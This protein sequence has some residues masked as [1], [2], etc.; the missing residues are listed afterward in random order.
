MTALDVSYSKFEQFEATEYPK[1]SQ[2]DLSE[3]DTRSKLIDHLMMDVLGW[4]EPDIEREGHARD[5]FFDYEMSTAVFRFVIEAKRVQVTL[6]LPVSGNRVKLRTIYK[7]NKEAIDQ[8][9][10]YLFERSLQYGVLT[11]GHQFIIA[12]FVGQT[13]DDWRDGDAMFFKSFD[14]IKK[15]FNLFYELLSRE[16]VM[17][18]ARIKIAHD[19]TQA[20]LI[21]KMDLAHKHA[22]LNRNHASPQLIPILNTVFE[23]LFRTAS[24]SDREILKHCYVENEDVKKKYSELQGL[25]SDDPPKFDARI[26]PV[27]NTRNTQSQIKE[28]L[29]SA[30]LMRNPIV[31]IGSAGAGK[32]TFI[33]NF[34]EVVLTD[35]E[36]RKRPTVYVDFT[37]Y[38]DQLIRDTQAICTRILARIQESNPGLNLSERG[39]L[40][41]IYRRQLEDRRKGLWNEVGMTEQV[42]E[43]KTT[44]YMEEA[45][46]DAN[47]HLINVANYLCEQCDKR[48][49]LILDNADQLDEPSQKAVFLLAQS[50]NK[51]M[52]CTVVL[53]LRE[54]YFFEWKDRPPFNAYTSTVYHITAPPY[55]EVLRKRIDY[56]LKGQSFADTDIELGN[57]RVEFKRGS[58]KT[59][60]ENL[61]KSLFE[62]ANSSMV[63]FLEE[64]S[65]PNIRAGL[66]LFHRFLLSGHTHMSDY[67][68]LEYRGGIPF[69]EFIKSV[70]LDSDYY[71]TDQSK[72]VNLYKPSV[73]NV[74]HFTKIRLL[75]FLQNVKVRAGGAQQFVPIERCLQA[76]VRVGYN[77]DVIIEELNELYRANLISSAD[78]SSDREELGHINTDSMISVTSA[79][80]YYISTLVNTF[81]YTDLVLQNTPIYDGKAFEALSMAFPPCD[82]QGKRDLAGRIHTVSLFLDYLRAQ[83]IQDLRR[84]RNDDDDEALSFKIV[85]RIDESCRPE[86]EN[87][88]KAMV[89]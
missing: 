72:V 87:I 61:Y 5:G 30:D 60:F 21:S 45:L 23:G 16:R 49:C 35:A 57:K 82:A 32:T 50:I 81:A 73:S 86:L 31:V 10:F 75:R 12:K 39:V 79:G 11:N 28:D 43:Q 51:T 4:T 80:V 27:Q 68:A 6:D 84:E 69:W 40:K 64:M 2:A 34:F 14:D 8:I 88:R 38:S 26:A 29:F 66:E 15:N 1:Y 83:E 71:Y 74:N 54:G 18:N 47:F 20:Q 78:Y 22:K 65:Y 3:S 7:S 67:M 77:A 24:L 89:R 58:I 63:S 85:K 48:L 44:A 17:F 13:G 33:K 70:A 52:P 46:R 56:V 59:L 41:T 53:A 76:F 36:K 62:E 42:L 25:L 19:T 37:E 9:R 55:R